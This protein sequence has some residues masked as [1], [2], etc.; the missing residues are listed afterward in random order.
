MELLKPPRALLL[1]GNYPCSENLIDLCVESPQL[2]DGY[3]LKLLSVHDSTQSASQIARGFFL[4][5][6]PGP[7][8]LA[9][10]STATCRDTWRRSLCLGPADRD[11]ERMW[12]GRGVRG[13]R[14]ARVRFQAPGSPT[15]NRRNRTVRL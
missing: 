10:L 11:E 9:I 15:I 4:A 12:A 7:S 2:I 13:P 1:F 5:F 3:V 14:R 8:C 6:A